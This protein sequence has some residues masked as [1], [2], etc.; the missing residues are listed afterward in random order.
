MPKFIKIYGLWI[1]YVA[2]VACA[3]LF[4]SREGLL[5]AEGDYA[6]AKYVVVAV[7]LAFLA[8][9]IFATGRENFFKSVNVIIQLYWGRQIGADLYISVALSL[10][11]IYLVEG[12]L[13]VTLLWALPVLFFANLAILPYIL[14]NFTQIISHFLG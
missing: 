14:L 3:I 12:S 8:Y 2:F 9:S 11:L 6:V 5:T 7:F 1:F 10:A 4:G 13:L